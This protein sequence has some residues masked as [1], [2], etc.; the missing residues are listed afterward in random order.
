MEI[1]TVK[2]ILSNVHQSITTISRILQG[3]EML[4]D[5]SQKD[6]T[7]LMKGIVPPSWET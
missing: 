5:K 2:D 1:V 7:W 3:N 4:T 6:A